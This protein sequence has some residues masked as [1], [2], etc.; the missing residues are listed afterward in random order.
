MAKMILLFLALI[1]TNEGFAI[2][3]IW[4]GSASNL[5]G[6]INNWT[7]AQIPTSV[8]DVD[9][10]LVTNQPL[11]NSSYT[12]SS[13]ADC[14]TLNLQNGVTVTLTGK[15]LHVYG[16][17]VTGPSTAGT[18]AA[19]TGSGNNDAL[20]I[21][22][23]VTCAIGGNLTIDYLRPEPTGVAQVSGKLSIMK[24]LQVEGA[25]DVSGGTLIFKS[26]SDSQAAIYDYSFGGPLTK[27]GAGVI[28]M[29]RYVSSS[30]YH[31]I[32]APATINL[33]EFGASASGQYVPKFISGFCDEDTAGNGSP[34]GIVWAWDESESL[35]SSCPQY[36]WYAQGAGANS[37]V[38]VGYSAKLTAGVYTLTGVPYQNTT[39]TVSGLANSNWTCET[40][41]S[42]SQPFNYVSGW[43]MLAN[44]YLSPYNIGGSL[45]SGFDDAV[46]YDQG[47]GTYQPLTSTVIQNYPMGGILNGGYIAPFQ[48]VMV[49]RG[50]GGNITAT[51]TPLSGA[52]FT[53]NSSNCSATQNPTFYKRSN[54]Q[55]LTIK[56]TGNNHT[57]YTY[58]GFSSDASNVFD[59]GYDSR[60]L[61]SNRGVP[62]LY[63]RLNDAFMSVNTFHSIE[64]TSS[65]DLGIW[66]GA[67]GNFTLTFDG[68]S[69][70]DASVS[71]I[72]EDKLNGQLTDLRLTNTYSFAQTVVNNADRFVI[73]FNENTVSG[74]KNINGDILKMFCSGNTLYVDFSDIK[75]ADATIDIYNVL[76][77]N[78][79]SEKSGNSSIYSKQIVDLP[80]G[81]IIAKVTTGSFVQTG[82][83]LINNKK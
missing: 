52:T 73:H 26:T 18:N 22:S 51:P 1:M 80:T 54:F 20:H 36:G 38:G 9:I 72:L 13:H 47:S 14:R 45:S 19:I 15:Q 66:S 68:V 81:Y 34:N 4:D 57:D 78:I 30:G 39:Y 46:V 43:H 17:S 28:K 5:W 27:S 44:P 70:F 41:Q 8:D 53:F 3:I 75:N 48:G 35:N 71:I 64:E 63:T 77:Q 83:F 23:G 37:I 65:V 16:T 49:H 69:D 11:V 67:D 74:V 10:P 40:V 61:K 6:D 59:I 21:V 62:T 56:V 25:M 79:S 76:G 55:G 12:L 32:G 29:E 31:D 82:K 60:K 2:T 33:G 58:T 42:N 24:S 7:P 50:T